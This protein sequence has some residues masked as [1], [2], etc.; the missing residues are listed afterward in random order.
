MTFTQKIC[1]KKPEV[2]YYRQLEDDSRK[3]RYDGQKFSIY[4]VRNDKLKNFQE[5]QN[6]IFTLLNIQGRQKYDLYELFQL[7]KA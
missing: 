2:F 3:A 4:S 6:M 1:R 5:I 7:K